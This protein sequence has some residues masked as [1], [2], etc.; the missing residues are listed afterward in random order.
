[1]FWK[2]IKKYYL[3]YSSKIP[4]FKSLVVGS[5]YKQPAIRG[6]CHI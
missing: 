4:N 6:P 5:T 2:T 3:A 1:M